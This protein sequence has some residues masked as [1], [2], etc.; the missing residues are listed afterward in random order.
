[1]YS[2]RPISRSKSLPTN[3]SKT[4]PAIYCGMTTKPILIF[5]RYDYYSWPQKRRKR[6]HRHRT[7]LLIYCSNKTHFPR[8]PSAVALE[9]VFH[10]ATSA[11]PPSTPGKS[12][13]PVPWDT[14]P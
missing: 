8:A 7:S 12:P 10:G 3:S 5:S 6:H 2:P 13:L 14:A 4:P 9:D 1:Y 11:H